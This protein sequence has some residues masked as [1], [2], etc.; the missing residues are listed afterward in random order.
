MS[1]NDKIT[2]TE[3]NKMIKEMEAQRWKGEETP[4]KNLRKQIQTTMEYD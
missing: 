4:A 1:K 2:K 3:W